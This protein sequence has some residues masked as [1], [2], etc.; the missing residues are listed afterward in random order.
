MESK[1]DQY[2]Q[3]IKMFFCNHVND[4]TPVI[5]ALIIM[6]IFEQMLDGKFKPY[7]TPGTWHLKQYYILK[8]WTLETF[9]I[10]ES[11]IEVLHISY[12]NVLNVKVNTNRKLMLLSVDTNLAGELGV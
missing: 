6:S 9:E 4:H 3:H 5:L 2:M 1:K 10:S 7:C 11:K 12:N 8:V